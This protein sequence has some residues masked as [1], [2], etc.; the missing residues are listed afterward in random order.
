MFA[1]T[2]TK[3]TEADEIQKKL[4]DCAKESYGAEEKS[5]M[6]NC[7]KLGKDTCTKCL[8]KLNSKKKGDTEKYEAFTECFMKVGADEA[9]Q[10]ALVKCYLGAQWNEK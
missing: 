4:L 10:K 8:Y 5:T 6:K 3:C 7:F 2:D 1:L 9:R